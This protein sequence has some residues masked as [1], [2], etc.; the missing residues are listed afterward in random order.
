VSAEREHRAGG[1]G[2]KAAGGRGGDGQDGAPGA[3]QGPLGGRRQRSHGRVV[4]WEK[5]GGPYCVL[6]ERGGEGEGRYYYGAATTAA[7]A[8]A[9]EEDSAMGQIY[10]SIPARRSFG[11]A[12]A[13]LNVFN[14]LSTGVNVCCVKQWCSLRETIINQY[15]IFIM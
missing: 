10:G 15:T 7:T 1:V 5:T 8:T 2:A 14:S 3:R 9:T 6:W 11:A 13:A 4:Q 12:N